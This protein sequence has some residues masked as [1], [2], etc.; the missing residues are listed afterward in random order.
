MPEVEPV[1]SAVLPLRNMKDSLRRGALSV[2][3]RP[4]ATA[5]S[6]KHCRSGFREKVDAARRRTG[7]REFR[8]P[9]RPALRRRRFRRRRR[10][11]DD[12]DRPRREP[13]RDRRRARPGARLLRPQLPWAGRRH[14]RHAEPGRRAAPAAVDNGRPGDEDR[15]CFGARLDRA[16]HGRGSLPLGKPSI[17]RPQ[18]VF[19]NQTN[20]SGCGI[21]QAAMGPFYCPT[22]QKIY[23]DTSFFD[24]LQNRFGAAGDFAQAYVIAHEVGHHIQKLTGVLDSAQRAQQGVSAAEANAI[25]VKVE[26]QADC[27]AG[28]W[29]GNASDAQGR[30]CSSR[31]TSRKG[32]AP[33]RR[34]ATTLC[35]ARPGPGVSRELHPWQ[36]QAT[37][38]VASPGAGI[39]RPGPMR[40][41]R[42][43][44]A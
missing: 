37:Q 19:Y 8:G 13:F 43:L 17:S 41:V 4:F 33:P 36:R 28:V 1:T 25:Q 26:L 18:F 42:R 31:A 39:G 24:E 11:A 22:D 10:P 32:S 2:P 14:V 6:P 27:Y 16:P 15:W 9:Q 40:H 20:R 5:R 12:A 44:I 29:G 21:A 7:K 23:L 3:A 34:S 30:S 35:S 38:R